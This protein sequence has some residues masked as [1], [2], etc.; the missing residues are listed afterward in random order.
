MEA[1]PKDSV[2]NELKSKADANGGSF[3][4]ALYLL[5]FSSY[6]G[7]NVKDRGVVYE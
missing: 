4:L 7:F 6:N 2:F 5:G 1:I 3:P